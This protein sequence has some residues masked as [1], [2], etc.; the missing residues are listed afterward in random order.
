MEFLLSFAQRREDIVLYHLLKN[1][2]API[3]YVDVGAR[4][5]IIGSLTKLFYDRGASGINIEP[6]H[7]PFVQLEKDRPR[8]INLEIGISDKAGELT[9]YGSSAHAS[10]DPNNSVSQKVAHIVPVLSLSDVFNKYIRRDEDIH[11]LKL[12]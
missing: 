10:F 11:F 4:D 8:D 6:Q 1:V 7:D 2:N 3:R 12:M 5:P 9:L